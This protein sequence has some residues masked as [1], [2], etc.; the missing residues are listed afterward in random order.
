MS[1]LNNAN[2]DVVKRPKVFGAII[3][4]IVLAAVFYFAWWSPEG[5]KLSS[6]NQTKQQEAQQISSLQAQ[7]VTIQREVNFVTKYQSFLTFF[8]SE[9]PSSPE[10]GPLYT[11][12]AKL[13][14][15]DK[16]SWTLISATTPQP[17]V[18]PS[19]L[20]TIPLTMQVGGNHANV[21]KFL[22]DLYTL[23]RLVTIQSVSPSPNPAPGPL[24]NV[25]NLHDQVPFSL[26]I[27]GT[28]YFTTG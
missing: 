21:L 23:P 27:T 12:L 4:V 11:M 18:A 15:S 3:A 26:S 9:L 14:N 25:L 13:A 10:Q 22:S 1:R 6:I 16:V 2:F 28:A 17:P 8:G 19:T 20:G 5:N 7:L 24:Y